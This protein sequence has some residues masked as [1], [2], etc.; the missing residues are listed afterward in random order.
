M[1][2]VRHVM[3]M[4]EQLTGAQ[5]IIHSRMSQKWKA[6]VVL[7]H[8]T[9]SAFHSWFSLLMHVP[10]TIPTKDGYE[11]L[12]F[13]RSAFAQFSFNLDHPLRSSLV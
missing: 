6:R 4:S 7:W 13:C 8:E 5:K 9:S 3:T 11:G 1:R 2:Y 10:P 12:D